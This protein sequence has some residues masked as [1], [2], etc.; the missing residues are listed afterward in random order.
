MDKDYRNKAA[1]ACIRYAAVLD[2]IHGFKAMISEALE[3][4]G[5]PFKAVVGSIGQSELTAPQSHLGRY[6]QVG[7]RLPVDS[8]LG[9]EPDDDFGSEI[10]DCEACMKAY[11]LCIRRKRLRQK[12]GQALRLVRYYG[13]KAAEVTNG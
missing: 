10:F 1:D 11:A 2:E 3:G 4:C 5:E 9:E 12:R 8:W 6:F 7:G 13:R